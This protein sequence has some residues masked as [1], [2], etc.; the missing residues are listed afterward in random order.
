[1]VK[2]KGKKGMAQG[3]VIPLD[4]NVNQNLYQI[5]KSQLVHTSNLF[6]LPPFLLIALE[7][8]GL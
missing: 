8:C 2:R 7:G 5:Q 4:L 1:M 3:K 6:F